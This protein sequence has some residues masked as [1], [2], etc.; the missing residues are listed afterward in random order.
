M[1][2]GKRIVAIGKHVW[3]YKSFCAA[4]QVRKT[5]SSK[6]HIPSDI[7]RW[8]NRIFKNGVGYEQK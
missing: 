8:S 6:Y 7:L 4:A 3:D 1:R 5:I 2:E